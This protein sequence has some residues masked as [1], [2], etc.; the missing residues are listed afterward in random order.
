MPGNPLANVTPEQLA[1]LPAAS[2]PQGVLPNLKNPHSDG[3]K[4][5]IAG[6]F[7]MTLMYVFAGVRFYMKL[8]VRKKITA[9]DCKAIVLPLA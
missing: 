2:P 4:L 5:I 7:L 1:A 8:F 9:D 3:P 6:A